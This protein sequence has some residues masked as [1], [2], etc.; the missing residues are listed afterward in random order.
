MLLLLGTCATWF[1]RGPHNCKCAPA[2]SNIKLGTNNHC[3]YAASRSFAT[4]L[5]YYSNCV[6]TNLFHILCQS[7]SRVLNRSLASVPWHQMETL[8]WGQHGG[9]RL[10]TSAAVRL[11]VTLQVGRRIKLH[12]RRPQRGK[13]LQPEHSWLVGLKFGGHLHGQTKFLSI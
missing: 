5:H 4:N 2:Y 13:R 1:S 6:F 3:W 12:R 8:Q 7:C 11:L 10:W 9:C